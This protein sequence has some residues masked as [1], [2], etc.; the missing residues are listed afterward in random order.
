MDDAA[1]AR[2]RMALLAA[3]R[4]VLQ[5]GLAMLGVSAPQTMGRDAPADPA[6]GTAANTAAQTAGDTA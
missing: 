3:V 1:L 4:Q 2:A 5:N 6:A